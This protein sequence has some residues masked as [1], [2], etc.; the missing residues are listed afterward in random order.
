LWNAAEKPWMGRF[1]ALQCEHLAVAIKGK[2][3]GLVAA[4]GGR[5]VGVV[6]DG[7]RDLADLPKKRSDTIYFSLQ[8][9][10]DGPEHA[11]PSEVPTGTIDGQYC[12]PDEGYV[13]APPSFPPALVE[14]RSPDGSQMIR[15]VP[16]SSR[17]FK[18]VLINVPVIFSFV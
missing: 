9:S 17:T 5:A 12:L 10:C 11:G 8:E 4:V 7:L 18:N 13:L 15:T 2:F 6:L 3:R 14:A 1:F 16:F